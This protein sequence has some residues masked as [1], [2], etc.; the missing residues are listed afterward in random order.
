MKHRPLVPILGFFALVLIISMACNISVDTGDVSEIVDQISEIAGTVVVDVNDPPPDQPPGNQGADVID[1]PAQPPS[2]LPP[3]PAGMVSVPAGNFQMG[4]DTTSLYDCSEARF[5]TG[6][7][8]EV[9]LH[10][11]YLDGY[12]IDIHEVT[13][14][15][16]AQ[17]V[18]AGACQPPVSHIYEGNLIWDD[19]H[20]GD[21]QYGNFPITNIPWV[22][23][24]NYCAWVGKSL[25]SEAQ[26]EKAA[27][28]SNDTRIWPWGNTPPNCSFLNFRAGG[29]P[30]WCGVN[31]NGVA[32][33]EVGSH[34][35][36]ASPYGVMDMAG[37][38]EEWVLD[39]GISDYYSYF[40]P[41]AW[42]PNPISGDRKPIYGKPEH[43]VR[44]GPWNAASIGVR[45]STRVFGG[46]GPST[47]IGFRCA[48]NP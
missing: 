31:V 41:D 38:V 20:Y 39:M 32:T 3:A 40:E 1:P 19:N 46:G 26:W 16:Y 21:A 48:S 37:N 25:P 23:G 33:A 15:Q 24:D 43:I 18:A 27:R 34:P 8:H 28:G 14:S 44:G 30:D 12:Y 45:V 42:P 36:G 2:E 11:V 29:D 35:L 13:N 10:T 17:C 47:L 7:S 4:C 6:G 22:D 5:G 9:P